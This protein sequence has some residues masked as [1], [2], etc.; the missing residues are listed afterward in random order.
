MLNGLTTIKKVNSKYMKTFKMA[1]AV[2][3]ASH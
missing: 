3:K 1:K 2:S